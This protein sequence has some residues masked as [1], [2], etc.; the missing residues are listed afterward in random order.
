MQ[1]SELQVTTLRVVSVLRRMGL[2]F[3]LTGGIASAFHGEPRFTQDV[4]IVVELTAASSRELVRALLADFV[5]QESMAMEAVRRGTCFQAL[6]RRTFI[7]VDLH[8]GGKIPGELSRSVLRPVFEG[9]ELPL[10]SKE[11]AIVSKLL[12]VS[13][14]SGKSR[15]DVMGM[16]ADPGSFDMPLVRALAGAVGCSKLL[17]ELVGEARAR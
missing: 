2:P 3:H 13:Q 6:D 17:E 8:V 9:V 12:W 7:K 16:L 4:D 15:H 1:E 14:G 10:V 11:D 5:V